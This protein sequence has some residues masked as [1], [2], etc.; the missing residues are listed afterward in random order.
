MNDIIYYIVISIVLVLLIFCVGIFTSSETAYLSLTKLKVRR[1]LEENKK[2]SKIVFKLKEK[3]DRLLTTVL[4]GTNFLNS[5]VSALAT[6]LVI[7]IFGGGGVGFPTLATAFFI[8]VFGQIIPKTI[9][10]LNPEMISCLTAKLLYFLQCLF[11]PLIWLFERLSHIVVWIIEKIVKPSNQL[12]TEEELKTLIDVGETEGT[13]E[14]DERR[15]MNKIIKFND[16]T[17]WDIMKHRTFVSSV[18]SKATYDEV[19]NEFLKSGFS[20]LTVYE[21][22]HE[23]VVGV[24]NYKTIL[25]SDIGDR[26]KGFAGRCKADV[27]FVPGTFSVLEL[28]QKFRTSP[29]KFAVVLSEQGETVGIATM[30][31]IIRVVFGR[32]TDENSYDN[33]P[34]EDKIKLVSVNTFLVPGE[35]HLD[36]LNEILGLNL[37][38]DNMNTIGGWLLEKIGYLP[39]SGKAIQI[40]NVFYTAEDINQRRIVTVRIKIL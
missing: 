20:N 5:L 15:M 31:D 26:G 35:I 14:K 24:L 37:E 22:N 33:L 19:L 38:S 34:A 1:L 2:N 39:Q 16:L 8:T 7:K 11:F 10:S 32:M 40:G 25:Y 9:A 36:D 17:V 18:D 29:L 28:L 3:M 27:L 13:I 12:I 30:E 21:E 6:A 4:I 23:N